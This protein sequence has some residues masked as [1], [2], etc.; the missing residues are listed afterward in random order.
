MCA[1]KSAGRVGGVVFVAPSVH[2]VTTAIGLAAS[3]VT[4]VG[5][6]DVECVC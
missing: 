4:A 1:G 2:V 3:I 5:A 6:K